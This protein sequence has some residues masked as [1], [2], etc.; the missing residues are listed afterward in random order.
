MYIRYLSYSRANST[1]PIFGISGCMSSTDESEATLSHDSARR[2]PWLNS[3]SDATTD[4]TMSQVVSNILKWYIT[5]AHIILYYIILYYIILYY[6]I[7]YYIILYYI[8]HEHWTKMGSFLCYLYLVFRLSE[9]WLGLSDSVTQIRDKNWL[10]Q[11]F[12]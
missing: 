9:K 8:I 1:C 3:A 4:Q 7:L 5:N 2:I 10:S 11:I 6:I 12:N